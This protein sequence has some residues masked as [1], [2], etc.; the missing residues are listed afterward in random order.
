M[1]DDPAAAGGKYGAADI[2]TK[3]KYRDFEKGF[4]VRLMLKYFDTTNI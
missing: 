4:M 3:K 1:T 2:V